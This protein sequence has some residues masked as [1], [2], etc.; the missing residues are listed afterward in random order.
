L[1]QRPAFYVV[2]AGLALAA[3]GEPPD[4]SEP[5]LDSA[6]PEII[7]FPGYIPVFTTVAGKADGVDAPQDLDFHPNAGREFEL[8][9]VNKGTE[10]T[11][12]DVVIVHDAGDEAPNDTEVRM[13]QNAWHFMSLPSAIA[14]GSNGNWATTPE[15]TDAN[16]SGGTFTGPTMWPGD[17]EVFAEPSG[18]NGSHLDMIHQS[19]NSMG[20][21][22]E[23]Q[24]VF[25]IFDGYTNDLVRYDFAGDH[26]PGGEYHGDGELERYSEV[27]IKRVSGTPS[28]MV[29]D[30]ETNWM[31]IADTKK[32]RVLRMD[33]TSGSVSHELSPQFE[34]L[35]SYT[36]MEGEI[37]EVFA[38]GLDTPC[39]IALH[40]EE[41]TVTDRET[42]EIIFFD[43]TTAEE[44]GRIQTDA[45]TIMGIVVGPDE[46]LYYVDRKGNKVVRIDAQ[47]EHAEAD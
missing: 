47:G 33:I 45:Q 42:G 19:P 2:C 28:H 46:K 29:I 1:S 7:P 15:V 4:S 44:L 22:H 37:W 34:P 17:L 32:G 43:R 3:C 11:G 10:A 26:G 13:D 35:A 8:W 18:G 16:H 9:V 20:I 38:E 31:Y 14:F 21:A 30:K 40:G 23:A 27:P 25:W 41:L 24:N 36:Q 12:G 39:G 5:G 6:A